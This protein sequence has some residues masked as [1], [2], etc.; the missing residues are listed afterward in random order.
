[1]RRLIAATVLIALNSIMISAQQTDRQSVW[2]TVP[3]SAGVPASNTLPDVASFP[4]SEPRF[5]LG[6]ANPNN[7]IRPPSVDSTK[8]VGAFVVVNGAVYMPLPGSQFL[9]PIS[10]GGAS[11]CFSVD[12]PRRI[13][14]LREFTPRLASLEQSTQQSVPR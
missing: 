13:T 7:L 2:P 12:L 4:L 10:G 9:F 1:M 11:G 6:Q 14:S 5:T 3:G 8:Q